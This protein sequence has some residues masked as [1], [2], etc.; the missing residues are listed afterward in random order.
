MVSLKASGHVNGEQVPV[1]CVEWDPHAKKSKNMGDFGSDQYVEMICQ[2]PGMFS[3]V[4]ISKGG[5]RM[6]FTQGDDLLVEVDK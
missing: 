3:N 4:P 6:S 1:S 5:K 2:E